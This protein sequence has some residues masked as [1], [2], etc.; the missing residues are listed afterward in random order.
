MSGRV[1]VPPKRWCSL[2]D[3]SKP[4]IARV[5]HAAI[6]NHL[7][8]GTTNGLPALEDLFAPDK[9]TGDRMVKKCCGARVESLQTI[10]DPQQRMDMAFALIAQP[11]HAPLPEVEKFPVHFYT[12][13]ITLLRECLAPATDR[14]V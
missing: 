10:Q 4:S 1:N 14:G 5:T 8:P 11:A 13:G 9:I 3:I 7:S 6:V 2:T 12:D